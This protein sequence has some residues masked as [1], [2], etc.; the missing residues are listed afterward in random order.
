VTRS[1]EHLSLSFALATE[2]TAFGTPHMP[3]TTGCRRLVSGLQLVTGWL[4]IAFP[5]LLTRRGR[6]NASTRKRADGYPMT[7][8][9]RSRA[10]TGDSRN[11]RNS[12]KR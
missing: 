10:D 12:M 3:V 2:P 11:S 8:R 1:D 6:P 4:G 9:W 7:R 5:A